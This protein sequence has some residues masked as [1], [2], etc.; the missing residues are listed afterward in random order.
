V[1]R[2]NRGLLIIAIY[3]WCTA[4]LCGLLAVGLLKLLH[5]DVAE[6]TERVIR[7][8]RG[9]PDNQL[10]ARLLARLSLVEDPQLA[11]LSAASFG[12]AALFLVEGTGLYYEL[13]WAEYL[14]IVATASFVPLEI[15]ELIKQPDT[16]K[17]AILIVNLAIIVFLVIITRKRASSNQ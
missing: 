1:R 2:H 10:L 16:L 12:Y 4:V 13:R 11:K 9:D 15:Y 17:L 14:T 7:S 5:Q 6:V 8:L 3:K